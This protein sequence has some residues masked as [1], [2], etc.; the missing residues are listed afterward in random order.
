MVKHLLSIIWNQRKTNTWIWV[1]LVLVFIF[2]WFIVDYLLVV[3]YTLL[4]AKGYDTDHTYYVALAEKGDDSEG[5]IPL[6]VKTTRSGEDLLTIAERIRAY[7]GVEAVSLSRAAHPYCQNQRS[8]LM[9]SD[10]TLYVATQLLAVTPEYFKV[11]GIKTADGS[12]IPT[13]QLNEKTLIVT[14]TLEK[15]LFG[16]ASAVGKPMHNPQ[17]KGNYL[18]RSRTIAAVSQDLRYTEYAKAENALYEIMTPPMFAGARPED[19]YAIDLCIRVSPQADKDF[20]ERFRREMD[21]QLSVGNIYL[22]DVRTIESFHDDFV[23]DESNELHTLLA[24]LFFLLLNIF[25]G[26]IGTF[27]IRTEARKGEMG[28]RI[29]LGS[30]SRSLVVGLINEGML[31]LCLAVVPAAVVCLNLGLTNLVEVARLDFTALR[32]GVGILITFLLMALMIIIG[33]WYPAR[34]T[35]KIQPAEALHYE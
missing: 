27:W 26:I 30:T 29:A 15:A 35:T 25:L 31:L 13:D 20:P 17:D 24:V 16:T 2:L 4:S 32:F 7:P 10:T 21:E 1:E 34:N 9:G 28:L 12:D 14:P 8:R 6:D 11:F 3:G 22:L 19:I 33:V 5:Y 23:R 18:E